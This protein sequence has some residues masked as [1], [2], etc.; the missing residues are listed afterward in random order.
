MPS[1]LNVATQ[2]V[3]THVRVQPHYLGLSTS[4]SV[5]PAPLDPTANAHCRPSRFPICFTAPRT[6]ASR[7]AH[8]SL[9]LPF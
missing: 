1:L 5:V 8:L 7:S 2:P 9:S 6:T 4:C 3:A